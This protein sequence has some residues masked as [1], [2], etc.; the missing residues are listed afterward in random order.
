MSKQDAEPRVAGQLKG[1]ISLTIL[2][3][4]AIL[5][6]FAVFGLARGAA[7]NAVK[8]LPT[9][10]DISAD[11]KMPT[12]RAKFRALLLNQAMETYVLDHDGRY[13]KGPGWTDEIRPYLK[14]KSVIDAEG[15]PETVFALNSLVAGEK[16]Q[17][18]EEP[19]LTAAFFECESDKKDLVGGPELRYKRSGR[20]VYGMVD[21]EIKNFDGADSIGFRWS[22]RT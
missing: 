1:P 22:D 17:D 20:T 7:R 3:V 16:K 18:I 2:I 12:G 5:A 19:S 10:L 14:D 8:P 13:P 15:D 21:G 4:L 9:S 11:D 6:G